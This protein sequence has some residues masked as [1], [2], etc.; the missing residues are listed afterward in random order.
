MRSTETDPS[1]STWL[2]SW[3]QESQAVSYPAEEALAIWSVVHHPV[4]R[5]PRYELTPLDP[6]QAR[7][8]L[9]VIRGDRLEALYTVALAVGLRQGEALGLRWEDVDLD[10]G[11]MNVRHALQR[12][13]GRLVLVEPK[14]HTSRRTIALPAGTVAA[15]REHRRRQ[16]EERVLAGRRWQDQDLTFTT[17]IGTPLDGT[18]VTKRFQRLLAYAG[19][20]RQR[21]HDLR[22][23]CA[24]LLLAQG[25]HPR[26]VMEVLGHSQISL[27]MNTYSHVIPALQREAADRMEALLAGG[28]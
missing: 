19:L 3:L 6:A 21:F 1:T 7:R 15:L 13:D 24:S 28:A 12:V 22:H 14:S 20:P 8:L 27:T 18:A 23:A 2:Q 17:T 9:D 5:V 10:A 25:V 11:M 16:L 26:V 4:G